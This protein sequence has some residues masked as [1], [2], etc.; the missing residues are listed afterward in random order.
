MFWVDAVFR[1]RV[2][3][4]RES[5]EFLRSLGEGA[6]VTMG[7]GTHPASVANEAILRTLLR[8]PYMRPSQD[9]VDRVDGAG[10]AP[11]A[12]R[13]SEKSIQEGV[14]RVARLEAGSRPEVVRRWIHA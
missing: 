12:T 7:A 14:L 9:L 10:D 11:V 13:Y 5:I 2:M 4:G 1:R 3:R 6:G 8:P